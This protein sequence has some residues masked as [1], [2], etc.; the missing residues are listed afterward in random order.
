MSD[1]RHCII[2]NSNGEQSNIGSFSKDTVFE[3]RAEN[4]KRLKCIQVCD[5]ADE[6]WVFCLLS[7][8]LGT[9]LSVYG[10]EQCTSSPADAHNS[11]SSLAVLL[12]KRMRTV[13]TLKIATFF[14]IALPWVRGFNGNAGIGIFKRMVFDERKRLDRYRFGVVKWKSYGDAVTCYEKAD[15]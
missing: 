1:I 4:R 2:R 9:I 14:L 10:F 13:S 5:S 7:G 6:W 3:L 8:F 12:M 15:D 11:L